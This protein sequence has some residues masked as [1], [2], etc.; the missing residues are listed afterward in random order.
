MIFTNKNKLITLVCLI[1]APAFA[2]A[3]GAPELGNTKAF[4]HQKCG[5][6]TTLQIGN[7][8]EGRTVLGLKNK[9]TGELDLFVSAVPFDITGSYSKFKPVKYDTLSKHLVETGDENIDIV[10]GASTTGENKT[11]HQLALGNYTYECS[12]LVLW[13]NDR[14]ND[15]YGESVIDPETK[16]ESVV[17]VN[18]K[19]KEQKTESSATHQTKSTSSPAVKVEAG[20]APKP[21]V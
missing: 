17:K 11:H 10:W 4:A 3:K 13:P 8:A 1:L 14:A 9:T 18:P 7:T 6:N 16:N 2:I 20:S 12:N 19:G 5:E 21:K 15:L